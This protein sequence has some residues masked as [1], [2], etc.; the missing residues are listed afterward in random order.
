VSQNERLRIEIETQLVK[1]RRELEKDTR[2]L[3]TDIQTQFAKLHQE[4]DENNFELLTEIQTKQLTVLQVIQILQVAIE[5]SQSHLTNAFEA[6]VE[7]VQHH[8]DARF[9]EFAANV[10]ASSLEREI[11]RPTIKTKS[12]RES[13]SVVSGEGLVVTDLTSDVA[14]ALPRREAL[15]FRRLIMGKTVGLIA[16]ELGVSVKVVIDILLNRLQLARPVSRESDVIRPAE[17]EAKQKAEERTK[18]K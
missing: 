5:K 13:E 15:V 16:Q 9:E 7:S 6:K 8:I 14:M 1:L 3:K 18:E 11:L 4:Y 10:G 17:Q 12:P 2:E